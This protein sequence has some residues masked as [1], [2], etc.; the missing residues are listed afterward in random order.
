ML[1]RLQLS[2]VECRQAYEAFVSGAIKS[3][4]HG[5]LLDDMSGTPT[6]ID[7]AKLE[8]T[9]RKAFAPHIEPDSRRNGGTATNVSAARPSTNGSITEIELLR[10]SFNRGQPESWCENDTKWQAAAR[11]THVPKYFHHLFL[12]ERLSN[13]ALDPYMSAK[14]FQVQIDFLNRAM[15]VSAGAMVW[16]LLKMGADFHY[17]A[18]IDYIVRKSDEAAVQHRTRSIHAMNKTGSSG[19]P[20]T[21]TEKIESYRVQLIEKFLQRNILV[22]LSPEYGWLKDLHFQGYSL[23]DLAEILVD[24]RN[25]APWIC[26]APADAKLGGAPKDV[27]HAS[28]CAHKLIARLVA[29]LG[30]CD[31]EVPAVPK[32]LRAET[33]ERV[34]ELCGLGGVV[35]NYRGE[36]GTYGA[37]TFSDDHSTCKV[38]YVKS[39]IRVLTCLRAA[40]KLVQESQYC[41]D[42]FTMLFRVNA[43]VEF[44]EFPMAGASRLWEMLRRTIYDHYDILQDTKAQN[45]LRVILKTISLSPEEGEWTF[46]SIL[47][48]I[49][50]AAQVLC[51][52]FL[53]YIQGHIGELDP[54]FLDTA[55]KRVE[56]CGLKD[57]PQI[58]AE[59][60]EL[61]C[62]S[63]LTRGP[64]IVFSSANLRSPPIPSAG[65]L[66]V[67]AT[68]EQLLDTWGP[69]SIAY[70]PNDPSRIF[71]IMIGDG[72]IY[73]DDVEAG[74]WHWKNGRVL[75]ANL[76]SFAPDAV[77]HVG[78]PFVVNKQCQQPGEEQC[79]NLVADALCELGT[80]DSR[81]VTDMRQIGGQAGMQYAMAT[82][83]MGQKRERG[84]SMK[85][86]ILA[87]ADNELV[88]ALDQYWGL[89]V[90]FCTGVAH[91]VALKELVSD[92]LPAFIDKTRQ[93]VWS[94][95]VAAQITNV[96]K[97][98]SI[99]DVWSWWSNLST[100]AH[101]TYVLNRVR[102]ILEGLEK[103]GYQQDKMVIAWVTPSQHRAV[104]V[105]H[106]DQ[107]YWARVLEDSR[108]CATFAY[109]TSKCLPADGLPCQTPLP[110]GHAQLAIMNRSPLLRLGKA[111]ATEMG[112]FRPNGSALVYSNPS[113]ASSQALQRLQDGR[114]YLIAKDG[115][116]VLVK[117]RRSSSGS[118]FHP[119]HLIVQGTKPL[120]APKAFMKRLGRMKIAEAMH[121]SDDLFIRERQR[122]EVVEQTLVKND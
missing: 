42:T 73:L 44:R 74:R 93:N 1:G 10:I 27:H 43:C 52:G 37:V 9:V 59:L 30:P 90:S 96:F 45:S 5:K 38:V 25:N 94:D 64:V 117:V 4:H 79:M 82:F 35:A 72:F 112:I 62:L 110:P 77:M 6:S 121:G 28:S 19:D 11:S 101:R 63:G 104:H 100:D 81:W 55:Q 26:Y 87:M 15:Q 49:T 13:I 2:I 40:M 89:Q 68:P 18:H 46:N 57:Q 29:G 41:C 22:G 69:G 88:D 17:A 97:D 67:V 111:L 60:V 92:L 39:S 48:F 33:V 34:A 32:Y 86:K 53:T 115:Y 47:H 85:H 105:I 109:M 31:S 83:Q 61:T 56:L 84:V 16:L 14:A 76:H 106:R 119:I 122:Q 91:R 36:A 70:D 58:K 54:A 8:K 102:H 108:E 20:L 24:R 71:A 103:T 120:T 66:D 99:H 65:R 113:S 114:D 75:P 98:K 23:N 78:N 107:M 95:L 21:L 7:V 12:A 51:V 80:S 50:L 116:N 118:S 3:L